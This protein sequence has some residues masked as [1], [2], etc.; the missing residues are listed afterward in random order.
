SMF[1]VYQDG[2]IILN[3]SSK[4]SVTAVCE[5]YNSLGQIITLK[6]IRINE[7]QNSVEL[8]GDFQNGIYYVSLFAGRN[9]LHTKFSI[10]D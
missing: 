2:A 3:I 9:V 8:E 4:E 10:M 6:N 5:V 1:S 7:G